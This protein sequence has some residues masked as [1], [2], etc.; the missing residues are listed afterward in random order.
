MSEGKYRQQEAEQ[1]EKARKWLEDLL[2]LEV[3]NDFFVALGDG[4]LLCSIVNTIRPGT[5]NKVFSAAR[6]KK[7]ISKK[8]DNINS[9]MA[10]ARRIGVFPSYMI[11]LNEFAARK[12]QDKL[13]KTLVKLQEI[14][15][16]AGIVRGSEAGQN[17]L[18]LQTQIEDEDR[19]K[20][21]AL[22]AEIAAKEK[23]EREAMEA[24][25]KEREL[26]QKREEEMHKVHEE[27]ERRFREETAA[28]GEKEREEKQRKLNE[29]RAKQ[30]QSRKQEA[31]DREQKEKERQEKIRLD[32]E[33]REK[34]LTDMKAEAAAKKPAPSSF[35]ATP[36]KLSGVD[37]LMYW[38]KQ[39]CQ[40]YGIEI[41]N[42]TTSWKDGLAFCALV[43]YHFPQK[44]DF[45]AC[46]SKTPNERMAL[47]FEVAGSQG[48][49][50]LLD[51]EDISEPQIPDRRSMITY[52]ICLYKGFRG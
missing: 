46:K 12:R 43:H 32:K 1:E 16:K 26:A 3:E 52:M 25:F 27:N 5:I 13:V 41:Q 45:N 38:S 36:V 35:S 24:Y 51:P 19:K 34:K 47:A 50:P 11:D 22:K 28:L 33:S 37:A 49:P 39:S 30:D 14:A 17:I 4:V 20:E 40:G 10:G 21:D 44:I 8:M 23:A 18:A 6:C 42:F 31:L 29:E 15:E 7:I 2:G 48:V 9:F